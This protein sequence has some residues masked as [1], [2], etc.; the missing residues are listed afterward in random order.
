MVRAIQVKRIHW[1]LFVVFIFFVLI[2]I[3]IVA[4]LFSLQ[5]LQYKKFIALAA[6]QQGNFQGITSRRGTIFFQDKSGNREA[7][8]INKDLYTVALDIKDIVDPGGLAGELAPLLLMKSSDIEGKISEGGPTH[9]IL[10][11]KVDE[12]AVKKIQ[13]LDVKGISFEDESRRMYPGGN[14]ASHVLGFVQFDKNEENGKYGIEKKF[15]NELSG[16]NGILDGIQNSASSLALVGRRIINPSVNGKDVVLTIDYNIQR[17]IE[18]KLALLMEKWQAEK[19]SITVVDPYTGKILALAVSPAFDPNNFGKTK[20]INIFLNPVVE[21]SYE[22]GSVMK[23]VTMASAIDRGVIK[24]D[25]TYTDTG[26]VKFGTYTIKNFDEQAHGIETMT[27]VLEKSLNTGA[28]FAEKR[29]GSEKFL[30]Y[31]KLFGFGEKTGID[32]PG[33]IP[34]NI[35]NLNSGRDIEFAT[36]A[37]GQGIA[38]TPMQMAMAGSVIANGGNL[39]TPYVVDR[40]IDDSGNEVVTKPEIKRQVIKKETA[41]TVTQMLVSV[42]EHGFDNH[43]AVPGYFVAGKTG[44]AQVPNSEGR[45]YS[46]DVIHSFLG[47]APAFQPKFL[48][49]MQLNRPRGV[50]FASTSLTPTFHDLAAYIL[51]YYGVP[52]D[53]K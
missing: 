10:Q 20:N 38:V 45:G 3:G 31:L 14:M 33:E 34:G 2:A 11:R 42:T 41:E 48:I 7:A 12:D 19:G 28:V 49:F 32:L 52:P 44:T 39:V 43:A 9:K 1:R 47:Y 30:Q 36:A 29:L 51:D 40:V 53:Q 13:A 46:S 37:F 25:T 5:I 16:D 24:P 18:E 22:L 23:P 35:S 21:S 8:A 17:R 15:Q 26:E 27:N 4:R 6:K 50:H